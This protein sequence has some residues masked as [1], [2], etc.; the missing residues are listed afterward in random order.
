LTNLLLLI[1]IPL[2]Q[3]EEKDVAVVDLV[4]SLEQEDIKYLINRVLEEDIVKLNY[5]LIKSII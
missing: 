4:A 3:R 1:I 5:K 2:H